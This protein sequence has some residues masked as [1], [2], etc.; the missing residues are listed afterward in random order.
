[1]DVRR[2]GEDKHPL[3]FLIQFG[4]IKNCMKPQNLVGFAISY[5]SFG[6]Y[7]VTGNFIHTVRKHQLLIYAKF[8]K[9]D[10]IL[11]TTCII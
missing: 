9:V 3:M 4:K 2:G 10:K 11:T 5:Y 1:M 6:L 7:I 8:F